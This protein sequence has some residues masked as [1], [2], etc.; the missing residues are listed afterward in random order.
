M[1][2]ALEETYRRAGSLRRQRRIG[3]GAGVAALCVALLGVMSLLQTAERE[4]D[5]AASPGPSTTTTFFAAVEETTT[6]FDPTSTTAPDDTTTTSVPTTTTSTTRR[7]DPTTTTTAA[8]APPR[9]YATPKCG[10]GTDPRCGEFRWEPEPGPNAPMEVT[11]TVSPANPKVGQDV[12]FAV[13][14]R[15]ADHV[16][17]REACDTDTQ[18]GDEAD[19]TSCDYAAS[20]VAYY[21]PVEPPAKQ[22]DEWRVELRH[23]Y[24]APGT[25]TARFERSGGRGCH[26]PYSSDAVGEVT[27][28]VS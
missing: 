1:D 8:P 26:D 21:G 24:S 9:R 20:C 4:V 3:A 2:E 23:R 11:V 25:Y 17:S 27:V 19:P 5:V 28:T 7:G 13:V 16:V 15:D 22:P 6:T 18:Y 14:A 10:N 12:V